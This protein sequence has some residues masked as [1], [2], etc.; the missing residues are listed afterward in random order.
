MHTWI[1]GVTAFGNQ[2]VSV[3]GFRFFTF[4]LIFF[5][6]FQLNNIQFLVKFAESLCPIVALNAA[7]K[8]KRERE[9]VEG[10]RGGKREK[11]VKNLLPSKVKLFSNSKTVWFF[12]LAFCIFFF[13]FPLFLLLLYSLLSACVRKGGRN[14][15][16]G[17]PSYQSTWRGQTAREI[18]RGSRKQQP[19]RKE[20]L[21]STK[22]TRGQNRHHS[23]PSTIQPNTNNNK[24]LTSEL[25]KSQ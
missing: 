15:A 6:F 24:S 17:H 2:P 22:P 16:R 19:I 14:A 23:K 3:S 25:S 13:D 18:L 5:S 11:G 1:F 10:W 20:Q 9:R 8:G 4:S 7:N 12:H 21:S